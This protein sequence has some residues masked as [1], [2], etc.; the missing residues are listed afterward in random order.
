MAG[1][2]RLRLV[3]ARCGWVWSGVGG[4]VG[5]TGWP[6]AAGSVGR[7][8]WR[9]RWWLARASGGNCSI[10]GATR[11]RHAVA[12]RLVVQ[13]P[14]LGG[15]A[16]AGERWLGGQATG[17][18]PVIR[19]WWRARW[20]LARAN[21]GG[22]CSIR[23]ATRRRHAVA[24]R[25]VVQNPRWAAECGPVGRRW[26]RARP[27]LGRVVAGCSWRGS[28]AG[29]WLPRANG[30]NCSIRGATRRRHAVAVRLVVQTPR[31]AAGRGRRAG[32]ELLVGGPSRHGS[33]VV[34]TVTRCSA[35][36]PPD[37]HAGG[38]AHARNRGFAC[39]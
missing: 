8:W 24:M 22:N 13:N 1:R 35:G 31:W 30:G 27:W 29:P 12:V 14:P 2:A 9:A 33:P 32:G 7:R 34:H 23:G 4:R 21:G 25:L 38:G 37:M 15:G 39:G 28:P 6:P 17:R 36:K 20:R 26:R 11:R 10:R 16:W 3:G 19:R 5:R 18:G